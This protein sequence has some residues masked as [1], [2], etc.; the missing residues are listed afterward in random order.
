MGVIRNCI[1]GKQCDKKWAELTQTD[2][3][4]VR[5]CSACEQNVYLCQDEYTLAEAIQENRCVAVDIDENVRLLGEPLP[6]PYS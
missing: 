5:Y 4:D 2:N 3:Q 1:F 6:L